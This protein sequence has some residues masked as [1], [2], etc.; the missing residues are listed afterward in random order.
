[1]ARKAPR[2]KLDGGGWGVAQVF[3]NVPAPPVKDHGDEVGNDPVLYA[4]QL[5]GRHEVQPP[6]QE[7][8]EEREERVEE[9][10][11]KETQH[12]CL[13]LKS[14]ESEGVEENEKTHYIGADEQGMKNIGEQVR[15]EAQ[16]GGTAP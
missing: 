6:E 10:D 1:M 7:N 2:R 15:E 12:F 11:M 4:A 8:G 13:V 9:E 3:E 14:G 5:H 16:H